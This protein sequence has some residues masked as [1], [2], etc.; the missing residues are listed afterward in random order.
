MKSKKAAPGFLA[1]FK[2]FVEFLQGL[3]GI[4][5]GISTLFPLSNTF[6]KVVPLASWPEGGFAYFSPGVVSAVA[7]LIC[8]FVI[9]WTFGQRQRLVS[10]SS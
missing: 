7:T 6:L 4:L 3:W 10:V 2:R 8:L 1:D 5:A 9:L